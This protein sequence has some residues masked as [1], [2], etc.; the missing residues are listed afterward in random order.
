MHL[1]RVPEAIIC[2]CIMENHHYAVRHHILTSALPLHGS[3][4]SLP[5]DNEFHKLVASCVAQKVYGRFW[6]LETFWRLVPHEQ[7]K[8]ICLVRC[9]SRVYAEKQD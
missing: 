9:T 6:R 5:L 2:E 4:R 1:E 8:T 7:S 3:T